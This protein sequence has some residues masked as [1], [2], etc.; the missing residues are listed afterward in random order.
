MSDI[1]SDQQAP[2]ERLRAGLYAVYARWKCI[3]DDGWGVTSLSTAMALEA[4]QA[5]A[6]AYPDDPYYRIAL[7][8]L[9]REGGPL[10]TLTHWPARPDPP[11]DG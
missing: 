5:L 11:S 1:L 8:E 6:E 3:H 9:E 10:P 4:M 7:A 2:D